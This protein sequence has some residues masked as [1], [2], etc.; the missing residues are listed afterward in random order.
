MNANCKTHPFL[1]QLTLAAAATTTVA[2]AVATQGRGV[3]SQSLLSFLDM[4][5]TI[6]EEGRCRLD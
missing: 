6:E 3:G 4:L 5:Q 2:I 1:I